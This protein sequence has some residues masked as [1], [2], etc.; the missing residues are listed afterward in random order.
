M[1]DILYTD[2]RT[3]VAAFSDSVT[4]CSAYPPFA[5]SCGVGFTSHFVLFRKGR[6][7]RLWLYLSPSPH[8][9]VSFIGWR[10][11]ADGERPNRDHNIHCMT[12]VERICLIDQVKLAGSFILVDQFICLYHN[13]FHVLCGHFE[14]VCLSVRL[15]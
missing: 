1:Y 8:A 4:S 14:I 12:K 5:V 10:S 3:R 9:S 15:A 11:K 7:A 6:V 2:D 13:N